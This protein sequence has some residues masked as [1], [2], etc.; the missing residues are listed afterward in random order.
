MPI[1]PK[2]GGTDVIDLSGNGMGA[3]INS[4][5][6]HV[7][8]TDRGLEI[9]DGKVLT[10]NDIQVLGPQQPAINDGLTDAQKIA[11]ILTALRAHGIIH[12]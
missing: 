3:D 4:D 12:V 9:A 10:F 5:D 7:F 1:D 11:A 6:D 8:V 2:P